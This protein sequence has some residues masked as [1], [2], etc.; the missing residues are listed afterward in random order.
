MSSQL[1]VSIIILFPLKSIPLAREMATWRLP[2]CRLGHAHASVFATFASVAVR[3]RCHSGA[4][5][6]RIR[7][8]AREIKT[9]T[10]H[11]LRRF[12][13]H[14]PEKHSSRKRDCNLTVA[15]LSAR[16]CPCK[17]GRVARLCRCKTRETLEERL[18]PLVLELNSTLLANLEKR[19]SRKRD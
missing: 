17:H 8:L 7:T 15:C 1:S 18:R 14:T 3:P 12:V 11:L 4:E 6:D 2:A 16:S 13:I 5:G 9:L 10:F 19:A